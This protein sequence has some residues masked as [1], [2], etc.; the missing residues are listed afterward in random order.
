VYTTW[1]CQAVDT[2]W[3]CQAV[4]TIWDCQ[5]VGTAWECQAVDTAW[6]CQAVDTAWDCQAV[7]TAWDCQAVDTAW[8]CHSV[9]TS[10]DCQVFDTSWDC[11]AFDTS[12][13][14]KMPSSTFPHKC[15]SERKKH[16][17]GL[18][19]CSVARGEE[20]DKFVHPI[21]KDQKEEGTEPS[22]MI[23]PKRRRLR[24]SKFKPEP[25]VNNDGFEK[26]EKILAA[27]K[28]KSIIVKKCNKCGRPIKGHPLPRGTLCSL[29]PLHLIEEIQSKQHLIRLEKDRIRK[30]SQNA[31]VKA[32]ERGKSEM[33]LEKA[34]ERGKSEMALEKARERGKSEMALANARERGKSETALSKARERKKSEEAMTKARGRKK[35]E[36]ALANA[37]NRNKT[38]EA[39]VKDKV[40]KIVTRKSKQKSKEFFGWT[41]NNKRNPVERYNL[42]N[43][44]EICIDCGA[45]MFPWERNKMKENEG[46]TFSLCCSY[47]ST[48]LTPFKDPSPELKKLFERN[49]S[50]SRQFLENIR[51]Y[52][53][54]VAMSSK[55]ISGKLTDFSK[56]KS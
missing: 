30:K 13:T 10:W 26:N 37:R 35:S 25:E 28:E 33:A 21:D 36:I 8:D 16:Q 39:K 18:G 23:L 22:K 49:S 20:S 53:G 56:C 38:N 4:D 11:Q 52:N 9:D 32:R 40:R 54:L 27:D 19:L 51:K 17:C 31:L 46:L 43:M 6:D 12:F 29:E 45:K 5:A 50:Q 15:G 14:L 48:R 24:S 55:N 34:R 44:T 42:P 41:D 47:G 2:A 1:N 3:D 7:D